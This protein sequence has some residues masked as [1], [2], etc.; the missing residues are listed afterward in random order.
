MSDRSTVFRLAV[1]TSP[2]LPA[3]QPDD[4]ALAIALAAAGV[5]CTVC[6]WSDPAIAWSAFDAV[7]IRTVWDYFKR[8]A[9]FV[10]WLDQLD[11]IGIPT[12]NDSALLR[13]NSDKRYLIELARHGVDIIPTTLASV[14][15]LPSLLASM[16]MQE[17]VIKPT[18]SGGA[19]HT[20]RGSTGDKAL[21]TAIEKLPTELH[22]L[23][24]P[25]VPEIISEGEWSLLFFDGDFSHA[26]LKRPV[27][28]DFRVQAEFG[29]S[30]TPLRPDA[31]TIDAARQAL[32]AVQAAGHGRPTYVRVDGVLCEERFL[33]MELEMIEPFLFL[34]TDAHASA[35]LASAVL[36]RLRANEASQRRGSD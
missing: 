33:V 17:V 18:V 12:I 23:V 35:S 32:A 28:G 11:R 27:G 8:H 10:E 6:V 24:Q 9:G 34:G 4:R 25:F 5:E 14:A 15:Q 2:E 26:V 31:T 1:A 29:G 21:A 3:I 30:V 7:L 36:R 19:W 16:P 22:Y 13:W 20:V